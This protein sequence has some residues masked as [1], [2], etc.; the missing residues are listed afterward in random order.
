M[1]I[2]VTGYLGEPHVTSQQER[3]INQASLGSG[4]Y[5]LQVGDQLSCTIDSAEQISIA[6]GGLSM[7][8]CV[9]MIPTGEVALFEIDSGT[10]GMK[11]ID[12]LVAKYTR[13]TSTGFESVELEV[14]TGTP[15][16][17]TPTPPQ[18]TTGSIE[19][20]DTL[21]E[22]PIWQININGLAI[23]SVQRAA[24]VVKSSAELMASVSSF[25]SLINGKTPF[26]GVTSGSDLITLL[27]SIATNTV[28]VFRGSGAFSTDVLQ[29][30]A[31]TNAFGLA[32][33][34]SST[35]CVLIAICGA[36]LYY[37]TY[38]TDGTGNAYNALDLTAVVE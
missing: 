19:D 38:K 3:F 20:G 16:S 10:S 30:D 27:G 4:T 5:V 18:Y 31:Q 33:K 36:K 24:P 22:A 17:G 23:E 15:S 11:R 26:Y 32:F 9:A 6:D 13:D 28:F 35:Q 2:I 8:G 29:T 37:A 1:N 14:K 21:V 12:Y 7:Q 34:N 25:T